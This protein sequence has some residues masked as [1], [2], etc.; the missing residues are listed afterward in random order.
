MTEPLALRDESVVPGLVVVRLG[1][2]TVED[3][4]LPF[5]LPVS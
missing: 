1:A 2:R 5:S 3:E 4:L